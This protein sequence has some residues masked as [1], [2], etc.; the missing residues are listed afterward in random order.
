MK[1]A[2]NRK[3]FHAFFPP[4]PTAG[5]RRLMMRRKAA[6]Y[7]RCAEIGCFRKSVPSKW[8][9][10]T[11]RNNENQIGERLFVRSQKKPELFGTVTDRSGDSL[12]NR[13]FDLIRIASPANSRF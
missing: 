3:T 10:K 12:V 8:Y 1:G 4:S 7:R 6:L 2:K 11:G 5:G 9:D 13:V